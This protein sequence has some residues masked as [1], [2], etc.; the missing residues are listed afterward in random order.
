MRRGIPALLFLLLKVVVF[1]LA[2]AFG[3]LGAQAQPETLR[4]EIAGASVSAGF[5]DGP[6]TGGAAENS[7][8]PLLPVLRGWF[9]EIDAKIHSRADAFMFVDAEK[10]GGLQI[11]RALRQDPHLVVAVDFLF[12]F[13]YGDLKVRDLKDAEARL[14]RLQVG[15]DLLDR[16]PGSILISD[17]PDMGGADRRMLRPAQI[18]ESTSLAKLN[19]AIAAWAKVRPRVRVFPLASTVAQMKER[20]VDLPSGDHILKTE[21][22]GLLQ[23]DRLHAT[24]LGMAFL[25][26]SLQPFVREL[27]PEAVRERLP[28]RTFVEFCAFAAAEVDLKDMERRLQ[29]RIEPEEKSKSGP[30]AKDAPPPGGGD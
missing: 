11:D 6:L 27:L 25:A 28:E 9:E 3:P 19:E 15:L 18:P 21:P 20:G 17:L 30:A 10:I 5:I 1:S 4:I 16:I 23:Q 12:W 13:A 26:C 24:R 14:Q 8:V 2:P 29:E 7:S 22:M